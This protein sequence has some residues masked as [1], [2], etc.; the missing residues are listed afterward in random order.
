M[1]ADLAEQ[2]GDNVGFMLMPGNDPNAPVA[3]GGESLPFAITT[4]AKNPDVAA[5]YIDFLTDA[6]AA[7]VLVDTNNLP[8]MKDAPAPAEGVSADVATAWQKLNEADGVIPYLDYT[9][10]TFSD[11]ISGAIQELL[12]GKQS[13]AEFTAGRAGE[14]R[15]VGGVPLT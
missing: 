6:N 13:P 11:D 8:A 5:A 4:A 12:A 1:T 10:P 9:T 15:R 7:K 3:L 2:M 14:V